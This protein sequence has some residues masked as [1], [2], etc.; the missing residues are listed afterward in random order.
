MWVF[1]QTTVKLAY[2]W[3]P[4]GQRTGGQAAEMITCPKNLWSKISEIV[5]LKMP[6]LFC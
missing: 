6:K 2:A 3:L 5:M 4:L 1:Y